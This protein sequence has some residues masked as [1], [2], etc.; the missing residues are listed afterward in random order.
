MY[1]IVV[2]CFGGDRSP[3]VNVKGAIK[4]LNEINDLYLIL[5]RSLFLVKQR[6][7]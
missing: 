6:D 2:D 5:S 4:A 1:K 7:R 3:E